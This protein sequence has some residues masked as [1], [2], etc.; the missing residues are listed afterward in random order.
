[1]P[2][3]P[4]TKLHGHMGPLGCRFSPT[5]SWTWALASC[6]ALFAICYLHVVWWDARP[7]TRLSH[8]HFVSF[9][10]L[11]LWDPL[12]R[13]REML[14]H[15]IVI[16]RKPPSS[17]PHIGAAGIPFDVIKTTECGQ[18]K[19]VLGHWFRSLSADLNG[20]F[21]YVVMGQDQC[22]NLEAVRLSLELSARW[23]VFPL[24][25][26]HA[27]EPHWLNNHGPNNENKKRT[28]R[29]LIS[30]WSSEAGILY[31]GYF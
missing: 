23:S 8:W 9:L 5:W 10:A 31:I 11:A 12:P 25:G 30:D 22:T 20:S 24:C 26:L 29:A 13:D 27:T 21:H 7:A 28:E 18:P 19:N 17:Q 4:L 15:C 3:G 1:M 14:M 16:D 6:Y 2:L